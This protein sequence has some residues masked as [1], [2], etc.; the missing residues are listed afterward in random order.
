MLTRVR[1][2]AAGLPEQEEV[3][4]PPATQVKI[5]ILTS[6]LPFFYFSCLL[7]I[8]SFHI[9]PNPSSLLYSSLSSLLFS[10]PSS[11]LLLS[12]IS[13]P[14][15]TSHLFINSLSS[16]HTTS[17]LFFVTSPLLSP[18]TD[19]ASMPLP[20]RTGIHPTSS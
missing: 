14:L 1:R 9:F 17:P 19:A 2:E 18:I 6:S 15:F 7:S 3:L 11:S 8:L 20:C 16:C 12:F 5:F 13:S 10:R 4:T